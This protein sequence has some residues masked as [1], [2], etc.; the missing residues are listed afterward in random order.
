M[1]SFI[2]KRM[3]IGELTEES[4]WNQ[5]AQHPKQF[6]VPLALPQ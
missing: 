3:L 4:N 1:K 5:G 6:D 2:L